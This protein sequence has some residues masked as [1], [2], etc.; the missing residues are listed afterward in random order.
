MLGLA[1][2]A[3]PVANPPPATD[4]F[5]ADPRWL[6]GDAA[7][8]LQL[9]ENRTLW[10]F[11][12]SFVDPEA[13]YDRREA[14]FPRNTIAIQTG[15]DPRNAIMRFAWDLRDGAP[16]SFF[17]DDGDAWFW[18]GGGTMLPDGQLAIFLRR[19]EATAASPP[20]GFRVAGYALVL[21]ANP[22]DEP[23]R[24]QMRRIDGP[25]LPFDAVP[26][27]AVLREDGSVFVLAHRERDQAGL[28]VR[29][30]AAA[31][32]RGDLD[33]GLWWAGDGFG[34][35]LASAI[36]RDGPAAI[37]TS[38]GTESS[39]HRDACGRLAHVTSSGFG[40]T[41][42]A[43]RVARRIEGPWSAPAILAR[44]RESDQP[45][46]FVYAGHAHPDQDG[47]GLALTYVANSF[48][49]DDLLTP[50]GQAGLYWPR[51][52]W[53]AEPSCTP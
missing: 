35:R 19:I 29:Y 24:W 26:G 11:G 41:Y 31:L 33:A 47:P 37:M 5:Q 34:W 53:A 10:L 28:L 36:G 32:A 30:P 22:S 20:L 7:I 16:Q 6:G 1:A 17:S 25:P 15:A 49:P 45:G 13:P 27:S 46:A 38:A 42:I 39:L 44:P 50:A 21:V 40:A 8:S 43:V 9:D 12:D 3:T 48:K 4:L 23:A 14:A 52:I 51:L 2:C 18:P